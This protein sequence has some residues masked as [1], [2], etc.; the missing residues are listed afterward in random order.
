MINAPT[1]AA[2]VLP[3]AHHDWS[4]PLFTDLY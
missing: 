4:N 3:E 2:A 1:N